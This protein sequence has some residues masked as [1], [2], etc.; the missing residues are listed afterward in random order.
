MGDYDRNIILLTD[1]QVFDTEIV[2]KIIHEIHN[3]NIGTTHTVGVGSGVSFDL[4]RRGAQNGGGEHMFIMDNEAMQ[5]QI[6]YLLESITK[7]KISEFTLNYN[8]DLVREIYPFEPNSLKKGREN[9]FYLKFKHPITAQILEE[10]CF[11][12]SWVDE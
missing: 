4:I 10:E 12:L 11:D 5:K 1:G 6:I 2:L 9:T 7:F 8:K 3:K